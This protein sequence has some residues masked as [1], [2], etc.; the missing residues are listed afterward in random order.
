[1]KTKR[2]S[3][4]LEASAT[5]SQEPVIS[6]EIG[7]VDYLTGTAIRGTF[8]EGLRMRGQTAEAEQWLG[9]GGP[10]WS[11]GW[12][13]TEAGLRCVPAPKSLAREKRGEG[14]IW[15]RFWQE[16]QT[17]EKQQW[18]RFGARWLAIDDQGQAVSGHQ[19]PT[20][21]DMHVGLHYGRQA[22]RTGA[23]FSR[24]SVPAGTRFEALVIGESVPD[25]QVMKP[26]WLGKRRTA[27]HGKTHCEWTDGRQGWPEDTSVKDGVAYVQLMSDC[28]VAGK[29]GGWLRGLD[30]K[31][32]QRVLGMKVAVDCGWSSF[33]LVWGWSASWGCARERALVIEAGSC[34][35]LRA[36]DGKELTKRLQQLQVAGLGARTHE[37]YGWV[38]VNPVWLMSGRD[39]KAVELDEKKT[40]EARRGAA[41][42][43]GFSAGNRDR[44]KELSKKARTV[45]CDVE[46]A[47]TL[48]TYARRTEDRDQCLAY[49]D[50]MANRPNDHGW[51]GFGTAVRPG[52]EETVDWQEAAFFLD[53]VV[54]WKK[55]E[56]K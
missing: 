16:P 26:C 54:V 28:L 31:D 38:A 27:G 46:K 24:R 43:P 34:W 2:V 47:V 14:T 42:W 20:E 23:L 9:L 7:T 3:F 10:R 15:N 44:L 56:G 37:G 25:G 45:E 51:K 4:R 41:P 50:A 35:R 13:V 1:M 19:V 12:P 22:S 53:A 6:N 40:L 17:K 48:G 33:R 30:E 29:N 18:T 8:F 52:L 32:W 5:I 39:G 21:S 36:A 49:L 11:P 55:K